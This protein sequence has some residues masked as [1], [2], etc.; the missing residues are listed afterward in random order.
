MK[1]VGYIS[2]TTFRYASGVRHSVIQME[3]K[4]DEEQRPSSVFIYVVL[5]LSI[6]EGQQILPSDL[7]PTQ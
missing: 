6:Y 4:T 1:L 7:D 3:T 2:K 5:Y